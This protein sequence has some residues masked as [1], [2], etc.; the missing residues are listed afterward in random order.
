VTAFRLHDAEL[1]NRRQGWPGP[2]PVIAPK[3]QDA[4]QAPCEDGPSAPPSSLG[5]WPLECWV[6]DCAFDRVDDVYCRR[7]GGVPGR[8]PV[9]AVRQPPVWAPAQ[10]EIFALLVSRGPMTLQAISDLRGVTKTTTHSTLRNLLDTGRA[11]KPRVGVYE[12]VQS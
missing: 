11:T 10:D 2:L 1:L 6:F 5:S 9:V 7:H 12:A 3:G 4:A 8:A